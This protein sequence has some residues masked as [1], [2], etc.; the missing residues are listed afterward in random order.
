MYL[1]FTDIFAVQSLIHAFQKFDLKFGGVNASHL[2]GN[3][4]MFGFVQC[5]SCWTTVLLN[6][7][8]NGI[9]VILIIMQNNNTVE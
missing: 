3:I 9:I 6:R 7:G 1:H 5:I 2:G 8:H 4:L